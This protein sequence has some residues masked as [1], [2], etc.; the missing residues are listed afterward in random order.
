MINLLPKEAKEVM[1][2][3]YRLR[4]VVLGMGAGTLALILGMVFL[5]PGYL[6]V[7]NQ[8]SQY[9]NLLA[10]VRSRNEQSVTSDVEKRAKTVNGDVALIEG[11]FKARSALASTVADLVQKHVVAGIALSSLEYDRGED[12]TAKAHLSLRGIAD[13]REALIAF[14]KELSGDSAFAAVDSP[15]SALAP[16]EKL[17]FSITATVV[18]KT[19]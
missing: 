11:T 13:T 17:S 1:V 10:S 16:R 6:F 8:Q 4:A 15:I 9:D 5:V 2:R 18:L 19:K 3:E 14:A 12:A 7:R